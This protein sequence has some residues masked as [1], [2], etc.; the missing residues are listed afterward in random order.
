M[1]DDFMIRGK[2]RDIHGNTLHRHRCRLRIISLNQ[3]LYNGFPRWCP[4]H[5]LF[6][7]IT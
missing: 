3:F 1:G 4:Q 5:G 7:T 2:D 6:K